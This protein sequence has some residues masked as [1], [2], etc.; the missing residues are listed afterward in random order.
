MNNKFC[1]ATL[2]HD[3]LNRDKFL[4]Q[5]IES[6][7]NH[8]SIPSIDW[9][10]AINGSNQSWVELSEELKQQYPQINF[11]FLFN[12]QNL[13]PGGG[14]NSVNKLVE[15]YEYVFFLEADW[16]C[17][18]KSISNIDKNWFNT[19]IQYLDSNQNI[20][21]ILLR[22]Y[23]HDVDDRQFGYNYWFSND[24]GFG[25][26]QNNIL[27]NIKFIDL[28]KKEYTNNPVIRRNKRFYDVGIFPLNEYNDEIKGNPNW[29]MAEIEA[30]PKGY[31]LGST[32]M[33]FGNFV[34][35]DDWPFETDWDKTLENITGCGDCKYGYL[36][37][38]KYFCALC[39]KKYDITTLIDHN[40]LYEHL[41]D[42]IYEKNLTEEE[43]NVIIKDKNGNPTLNLDTLNNYFI[44]YEN[45]VI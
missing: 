6:F 13:G 41:Y 39:D 3:A 31:N 24:G 1:I 10:I 2:T 11:T 12:E 4:K 5:T 43:I 25:I 18:P 7:I 38:K 45:Q 35:C 23:L 20:D 15:H 16:L 19:C 34:H 14:I 22:R 17:L 8:T 28:I 26:K 32:Y 37:P 27:N 36:L 40:K 21:Q 33:S 44:F 42:N 29:G 9:Y 30:E